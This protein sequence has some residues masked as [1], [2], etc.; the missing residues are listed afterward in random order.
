[1]PLDSPAP[2]SLERELLRRMLRIRRFAEHCA[3]LLPPHAGGEAVAVGVCQAL[4]PDDAI[5]CTHHEYGPALARGVPAR[6]IVATLHHAARGPLDAPAHVSDT[7]R[8]FHG[9]GLPVA[10]GLAIADQLLDR[11]RRVTACFFGECAPADAEWLV[12]AAQWRLPMLFVRESDGARHPS[13]PAGAGPGLVPWPGGLTARTVDGVDVWAVIAAAEQACE[14]VRAGAGPRFL[15][16]RT[17]RTSSA[18]PPG[19]DGGERDPLTRIMPAHTD[20]AALERE[21]AQ[22]LNEAL[23]SWQGPQADPLASVRA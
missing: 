7:G 8:R 22:E 9:G 16:L 15:D 20:L 19:P 2:A 6:E 3:D 17:A 4:T 18:L 11:R 5:V 13:P 21:I 14:S 10:V 1:M 23:T 12:L